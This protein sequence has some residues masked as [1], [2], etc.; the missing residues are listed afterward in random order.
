MLVIEK[1]DVVLQVFQALTQIMRIVKDSYGRLRKQFLV[2]E[3]E[4][5]LSKLA[6]IKCQLFL[7]E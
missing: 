6:I 2:Q 5:K 3:R 1:T 7:I 4:E